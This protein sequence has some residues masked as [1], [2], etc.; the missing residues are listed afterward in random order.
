M[1]RIPDD[2]A[3]LRD[4]L[5]ERQDILREYLFSQHHIDAFRR[6]DSYIFAGRD[7]GFHV[8]VRAGWLMAIASFP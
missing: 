4:R 3:G 8:A 5:N 1:P 7:L 6:V 2:L